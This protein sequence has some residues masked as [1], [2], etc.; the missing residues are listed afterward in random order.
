MTHFGFHGNC[1][2]CFQVAQNFFQQK[3]LF[4]DTAQM[5]LFLVFN[6][7]VNTETALCAY[8]KLIFNGNYVGW[9]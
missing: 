9:A 2:R 4:K 1:F 5:A 7:S 3:P 8:L 6:E